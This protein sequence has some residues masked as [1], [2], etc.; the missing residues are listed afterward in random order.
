MLITLDCYSLHVN[1]CSTRIAMSQSILRISER[2]G[3][4]SHNPREAVSRLIQMY[5]ADSGYTR[6]PFPAWACFGTSFIWS[7]TR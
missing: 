4:L 2:A 3:L 7:A 1:S 6:V 5:I